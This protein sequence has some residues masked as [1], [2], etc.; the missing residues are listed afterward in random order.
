MTT[1]APIHGMVP[2]QGAS[3]TTGLGG[4]DSEGFMK[5]LIAQLRYQNPLAPSDPTDMMLQ[6]SHLAQLDTMQQILSLQRRDIGLQQAVA[7]AGML[8]VE[9]FGHAPDGTPVE[10]VV[11]AVRYTEQ[12]PVLTVGDH[13]LPLGHVAEL[14][15]T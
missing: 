7:A 11:E 10:G 15:A 14:R 3:A 9:V 5:L 1:V 4:L 12:G 8:G 13:D 2:T 6:T